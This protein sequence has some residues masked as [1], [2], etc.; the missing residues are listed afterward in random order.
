MNVVLVCT[1]DDPTDYA[2]ASRGDRR[3][4][5]VPDPGA[6]HVP[7]R[8][9]DGRRVARRRSTP[10]STGWPRRPDVEIGDF[11]ALPGRACASGTISSTPRAAGSRTTASRRSTPRTTPTAELPRDLPPASAA[12][13]ALDADEIGQVQVGH[14]LRVR[15]DGPRRRAGRS[16][17]TS[18]PCGTTTRGCSGRSGPDTGFD[19][20]GDCAGRPAAGAVPRPAGPRRPAGQDDPLQPQP[21]RQRRAGHDDRQ[22][23]GRQHAGQDAVRQRLVVPRPEGRH[24][25]A[26][27]RAVE[28]WAC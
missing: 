3:R 20:I 28:P 11:A 19:S 6:A 13:S 26:A 22:L 15:P 8:Q 1:T 4:H 23:P 16:S 2:G 17:S 25:A 5:V 14:A 9:G 12:A 21:G 7:A 10:G 27:R 24:G 18:A